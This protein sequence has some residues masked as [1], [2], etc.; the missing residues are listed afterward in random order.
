MP[1]IPGSKLMFCAQNG[2][3]VAMLLVLATAAGCVPRPAATRAPER[4]SPEVV[5]SM[6][7][8]T[9]GQPADRQVTLPS[10]ATLK[11]AADWTVT[12]V[13]DGLTLEDPER[14]LKVELVEVA[15]SVGMNDAIAAAWLRR[16]PDFDRQELASS[17]S[18]GREGWDLFHWSRYKTSPAEA[19]RVSA[20]A[21][22]K[23]A[24]AVVVLIDGPLAAAQRRSSQIALVQ[25]SLRPA[26]YVRET[27]IGRT[28]RPLNAARVASL[29][30][31][32]DQ[33]REAADVPGVSVVL[34]DKDAVLIEQGFG[35]RERGWPEPVTADSLYIIASNTK[36]LT[37]LLLARLVDEGRFAWDTPVT[38]IYPAFRIGDP[39]VT[40]RILLKH[41]VCACTGLPRQDF[42]WL[43]T[44]ERSSPQGQLDVLAT[45]KPTTEFGA[46]YQYS[47]PLASA[48]GYIG[49]R[50]LKPDGELGQAYDDIMRDKVFRP[51]GMD[52]TTFSFDEALRTD[53]ASPHS[54]DMSLRNVPIDM[55]LNHSIIPVRPAGGAWSS[56]RDYARYVRLE[57]ARGRLPDG[58]PF[59]TEKNLLARRVPQVRVGEESWYGM[60]LSL[61]DV[62]GI[63]VV[64]H[65]GSMFG[66]KSN[67]FVVPDAGVGGVVL[68]N[69]DSGWNVTRAVMRRTLELIYDGK[70]EAEEDLLSAVR[71]SRAFLMGAQRD[72]KVPPEASEVKR[73]VGSFR[74]AAL[75]EIVVRAGQD[76]LVF[77]FGGWKSRMATRL[78]PDG[79]T[80]FVSIDPG[81]RGFEFHAAAASGAYRRLTVR[82][83]QHTYEYESSDR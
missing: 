68:T 10:G 43:F 49:A 46:L 38:Q 56:V 12:A 35:V 5:A 79:T 74:N 83:P 44:F 61:E 64:S 36:S 24:L 27:Y 41:L 45:M 47:N 14:Q 51:L 42:E 34:F 57:L 13:K 30:A 28:P 20:F 77:Q 55:G 78:N 75:G 66:Y 4:A 15:A 71:E 31:F 76:D 39:D 18:P 72:W 48:A 70:A 16:R 73:L 37:T 2:L 22:R 54:W 23:G 11:V 21:A 26:G 19:R 50:S 80:S 8:S 53:H 6:A 29:K 69:A 59:V 25:D 67:F 40:R 63:R 58:A 81:V 9:E 3:A 1:V 62:K 60:G 17:D 33:M 52:R 65:G 7:A 32:I 82:D